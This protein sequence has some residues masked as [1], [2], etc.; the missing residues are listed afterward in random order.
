MIYSCFLVKV[1]NTR[2][3][4]RELTEERKIEVLPKDLRLIETLNCDQRMTFN[5]IFDHVV[6][7]RGKVFFVMVLVGPVRLTYT[8]HY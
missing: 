3:Y 2:D 4:Y 6:N 5:E 8:G 1:D 7:N